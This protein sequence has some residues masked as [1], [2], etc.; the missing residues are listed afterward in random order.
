MRFVIGLVSGAA[1]VLLL[2]GGVA[3]G[4]W[5]SRL[6]AWFDQAARTAGDLLALP[7]RPPMSAE[8]TSA[9]QR[10]GSP[11]PAA[12]PAPAPAPDPH[13]EAGTEGPLPAGEPIPRPPDPNPMDAAGTMAQAGVE[14]NTPRRDRPA[15]AGTETGTE[16]V[17]DGVAGTLAD[18]G[19]DAVEPPVEGAAE[20]PVALQP[21][22]TPFHSR[23][24]ASGFAEQLTV[25]LNHPF[26]VE[27]RG[28]GQY[29][30]VFGY[31]DEPQREALLA[32][33]AELTGLRL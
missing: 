26:R 21:V 3:D 20:A 24:S 8:P 2:A 31:Q 14:S 32:Q 29:Q 19:S 18:A 10:G 13:L 25:S 9:S 7:P 15:G 16:A 6:P 23:L 33:A 11:A 28:P 30:V 1:A 22:W 27:R 4:S 5:Q 17:A 12:A